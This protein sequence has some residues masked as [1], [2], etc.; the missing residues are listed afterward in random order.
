[1][2]I[3]VKSENRADKTS[4]LDKLYSYLI[5]AFGSFD[6]FM[7]NQQFKRVIEEYEPI[8]GDVIF[9]D[10][11]D[12]VSEMENIPIPKILSDFGKFCNKY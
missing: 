9:A 4:I 12:I 7:S 11:V 5:H 6:K 1:M 2:S 3:S 10:L 8:F